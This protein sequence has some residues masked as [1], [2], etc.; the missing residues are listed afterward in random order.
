M[1]APDMRPTSPTRSGARP[2]FAL[3]LGAAL[4]LPLS[5]QD[6]A[7]PVRPD[8]VAVRARRGDSVT[9]VH[10][11]VTKNGLSDVVAVVDGKEE[12]FGSEFVLSLTF[13]DVPVA[14]RDGVLFSER[15]DHANAAAT[16]KLAAG[17]SQARPVVAA[18]ARLR[19]AEALLA[20][21]ASDATRFAEAAEQA[22]RFLADQAD[23]REVPR[24]QMVRARALLLA[25]K[26][27]EA[28]AAWRE[29]YGKLAG[30]SAAA[31]YSRAE[32]FR[33]GLYAAR[34]L[35]A[36][37][38]TLG[39][40]EL[41]NALTATL[42]PIVAG[43]DAAGAEHAQ[44][45]AVLDEAG[46]GEGFAELAA[47]NVP[48]ALTFFQNQQRGLSAES[49]ASQRF[50]TLLGLGE[51]LLASKRPR[52]AQ[53]ALAEVSALEPADRDRT[54]R[55]LLGQ[56]EAATALGESRER[57]QPLLDA[58]VNHY[59]DTPSAARARQMK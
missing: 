4:A 33:A 53:I 8:Q 54:A 41:F 19:A 9:Q 1:A 36:A 3:A 57:I 26:P 47:G 29:V 5:A 23:N 45:A 14:Y 7:R 40:R 55:A 46:L 43:L 34:A 50:G 28:A 42:G 20:W 51:A 32:C 10:G 58:I 52:E 16:F 38:D 31:G 35:L 30:D 2:L 49:R 11:L 17:D 59:G 12:K 15:G 18:A 13:G 24:A 56:V 37:A 22:E 44:L 48:Q 6:D 21:G 27:S 39:A 25:G